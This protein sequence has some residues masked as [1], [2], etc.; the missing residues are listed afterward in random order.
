MIHHPPKQI[1]DAYCCISCTDTTYGFS[2]LVLGGPLPVKPFLAVGPVDTYI[3]CFFYILQNKLLH[4]YQ[5]LQQ[6]S[7]VF[8]IL[9]STK[10]SSSCI[11]PRYAIVLRGSFRA[12]VPPLHSSQTRIGCGVSPERS[13]AHL[14]VRS[15][16]KIWKPYQSGCS[17]NIFRGIASGVAHCRYHIHHWVYHETEELGC[18]RTCP[19]LCVH[20]ADHGS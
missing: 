11:G 4:R 6:V 1:H 20:F 8:P 16:V 14:F 12:L 10:V 17:G 5:V 3:H 7:A 9:T 2:K 19:G 13:G 18:T 15:L